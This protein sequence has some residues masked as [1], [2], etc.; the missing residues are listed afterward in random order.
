ML[1]KRN[2]AFNACYKVVK[3]TAA[4]PF[5]WH[6]KHKG[7]DWCRARML[8]SH[9]SMSSSRLPRQARPQGRQHRPSLA[10][11]EPRRDNESSSVTSSQRALKLSRVK[12][13]CFSKP[14]LSHYVCHH[15]C[16]NPGTLHSANLQPMYCE[17]MIIWPT[18]I[19][20]H[21]FGAEVGGL[22]GAGGHKGGEV[23][24]G[25]WVGGRR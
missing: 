19:L 7:S 3:S 2:G 12:I 1:D 20:L 5:L 10:Q 22:S 23:S 6:F 21:L 8:L 18:F 14:S 24:G 16:H 15:H 25:A 9:W 17:D 4:P 13:N 11:A